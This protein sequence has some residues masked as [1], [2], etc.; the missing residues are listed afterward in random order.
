MKLFSLVLSSLS[1]NSSPDIIITFFELQ[2]KIYESGLKIFY[3]TLNQTLDLTVLLVS[4]LNERLSSRTLLM[5]CQLLFSSR[6]EVLSQ[7]SFL[8]CRNLI[9]GLGNINNNINQHISSVLNNMKK[10]YSS[11]FL[12]AGTQALN[13]EV[14]SLLSS[15]EKERLLFCFLN[16][17][18]ETVQ[19]MKQ[20]IDSVSKIL[21]RQANFDVI[22]S[23]EIAISSKNMKKNIIVLDN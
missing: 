16:V 10:F 23:T 8:L 20:L 2:T 11:E 3:S 1:A 13:S 5:F 12:Q 4:S 9:C 6:V 15:N 17:D 18:I 14:F 7:H 21:K 22:I 19:Q